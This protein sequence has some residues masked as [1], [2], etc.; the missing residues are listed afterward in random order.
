M[1]WQS[2]VDGNIQ[3]TRNKYKMGLPGNNRVGCDQICQCIEVF[4]TLI[5]SCY[6]RG[7]RFKE[8]WYVWTSRLLPCD[9]EDRVKFPQRIMTFGMKLFS[10]QL[11]NI[12]RRPTRVCG[13]SSHTSE[14]KKKWS[15]GSSSRTRVENFDCDVFS[16]VQRK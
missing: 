2:S 12:F 14:R 1:L 6:A 8:P 15:S 16:V 13:W 5:S 11:S 4:W 10:M 7:S 3:R 9:I